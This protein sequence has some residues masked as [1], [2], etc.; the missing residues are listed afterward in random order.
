MQGVVSIKTG[1]HLQ[2]WLLKWVQ[3]RVYPWMEGAN[4]PPSRVQDETV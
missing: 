2:H 4:L 1:D 3:L